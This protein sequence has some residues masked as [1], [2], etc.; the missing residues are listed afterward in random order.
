MICS[1]KNELI[2]AWAL[3]S[4][5]GSVVDTNCVSCASK[6]AGFNEDIS[7]IVHSK[8]VDDSWGVL[9][10][11]NSDG[12]KKQIEIGYNFFTTHNLMFPKFFCIN[13]RFHFTFCVCDNRHTNFYLDINGKCNRSINPASNGFMTFEK[14][15]GGVLST[16][17]KNLLLRWK[18]LG[19]DLPIFIRLYLQ[20]GVR[21]V[22]PVIRRGGVRFFFFGVLTESGSISWMEC[23]HSIYEFIYF[24]PNKN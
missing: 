8:W 1:R 22:W 6:L 21:D 4:V 10:Q 23:G 16:F 12:L 5:S 9:G 19:V 24:W 11:W 14:R 7:S 20:F 17:L 15:D 3:A 2:A 18:P 13:K